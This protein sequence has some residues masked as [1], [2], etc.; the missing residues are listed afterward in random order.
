MAEFVLPQSIFKYAV[1][2]MLGKAMDV[3]KPMAEQVKPVFTAPISPEDG[4][5]QEA[6]AAASA[7]AKIVQQGLARMKNDLREI[8]NM[9]RE[10]LSIQ[11]YTTDVLQPLFHLQ[12]R[13]LYL[14]ESQDIAERR[15]LDENF[16]KLCVRRFDRIVQQFENHIWRSCRTPKDFYKRKKRSSDPAYPPSNGTHIRMRRDDEDPILFSSTPQCVTMTVLQTRDFSQRA[17]NV[18]LDSLRST[19][20]SILSV[21]TVCIPHIVVDQE[22]IGTYLKRLQDKLQ[23]M[24]QGV[25]EMLDLVLAK[26]DAYDKDIFHRRMRAYTELDTAEQWLMTLKHQFDD[27]G[28]AGIDTAYIV[29]VSGRSNHSGYY[30]S[31]Q[32]D[33]P[34][35]GV[36]TGCKSFVWRSPTNRWSHEWDTLVQTEVEKLRTALEKNKDIAHKDVEAILTGELLRTFPNFILSWAPRDSPQPLAVMEAGQEV[37]GS[38]DISTHQYLFDTQDASIIYSLLLLHPYPP[39]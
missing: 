30:A 8:K 36:S 31:Q 32:R 7:L 33:L 22:L 28:R 6:I 38:Y 25:D 39:K 13:M 24:L 21:A 10:E 12:Q 35:Q 2:P 4:A 23:V 1:G 34:L 27:L 26:M 17:L 19:T 18:W 20:A 11:A 15:A 37:L 16:R 29:A 9:V 3:L 5:T 14:N